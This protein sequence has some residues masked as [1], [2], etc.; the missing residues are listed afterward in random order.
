MLELWVWA[1]YTLHLWVPVLVSGRCELKETLLLESTLLSFL[2]DEEA[3]VKRG[4][5][6]FPSGM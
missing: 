2:T 4:R 6:I 1:K 5:K 3:Q